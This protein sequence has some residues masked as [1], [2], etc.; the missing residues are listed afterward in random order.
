MTITLDAKLEAALKEEAGRRGITPEQLAVR[1]LQ[2]RFLT[3]PELQPR[4]Q[5][6]RDLLE[7]AIDCGASPPDWAFTSEGLYD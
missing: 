3:P 5:W 6:E 1:V 4:D 7:I 2:I